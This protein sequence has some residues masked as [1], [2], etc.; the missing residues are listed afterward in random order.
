MS[1][2]AGVVGRGGSGLWRAVGPT[3]TKEVAMEEPVARRVT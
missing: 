2:T 3:A 1:V